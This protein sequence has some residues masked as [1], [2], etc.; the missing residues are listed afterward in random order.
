MKFFY[1]LCTTIHLVFSTQNHYGFNKITQMHLPD[2]Y[3][4]LEINLSLST[5]KRVRERTLR[6]KRTAVELTG[7]C[8]YSPLNDNASRGFKSNAAKFETYLGFVKNVVFDTDAMTL[9]PLRDSLKRIGGRVE[10]SSEDAENQAENI[11]TGI[12]TKRD[13]SERVQFTNFHNG[14]LVSTTGSLGRQGKVISIPDKELDHERQADQFLNA[15]IKLDAAV[16]DLRISEN[17][18]ELCNVVLH[19]INIVSSWGT[20]IFE[21]FIY[22]VD[23]LTGGRI[24]ESMF[25]HDYIQALQIKINGQVDT[26]SVKATHIS[27]LDYAIKTEENLLQAIIFIPIYQE[28]YDLY[29]Y[30]GNLPFLLVNDE[31]YLLQVSP[32]N[33]YKFIAES[34]NNNFLFFTESAIEKCTKTPTTLYCPQTI[35]YLNQEILKSECLYNLFIE[36]PRRILSSCNVL[37][38]LVNN[39][40]EQLSP[41][42]YQVFS[43][44]QLEFTFAEEMG[45]DSQINEQMKIIELTNTSD[46]A[47]DPAFHVKFDPSLADET[48]EV[49]DHAEM[50]QYWGNIDD[51]PMFVKNRISSLKPFQRKLFFDFSE[52]IADTDYFKT[53][54]Y[55]L[56]SHLHIILTL[57]V[58]S[59]LKM[60][61]VKIF[62]LIIKCIKSLEQNELDDDF[63]NEM[64]PLNKSII[65]STGNAPPDHGFNAY[66]SPPY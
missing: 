55:N 56:E 50:S 8:A 45:N 18:D 24:P 54:I 59:G 40:A 37:G 46:L 10:F 32:I 58:L 64:K 4:H 27:Q 52:N 51:L 23:K 3:L 17:K 9:N 38:K 41:N 39:R 44:P 60:I 29:E 11:I 33:D 66:P 19:E 49:T 26:G 65:K 30:T 42:C 5:L 36:D 43:S 16:N 6:L 61:L 62:E 31:A 35:K 22:I 2:G 12:K 47:K 7:L 20:A 21:N 14:R 34:V 1:I 48:C 28:T 15:V 63:A 53:H 13:T 57:I 25:T